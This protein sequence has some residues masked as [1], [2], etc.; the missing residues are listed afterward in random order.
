MERVSD[1]RSPFSSPFGV[2]N[3]RLMIPVA[4]LLFLVVFMLCSVG[5]NTVNG[6]GKDLQSWT[7]DEAHGHY[8]AEEHRRE[9]RRY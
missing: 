1:C 7:A 3:M 9:Q 6:F 4:L 2:R 5:C 8:M